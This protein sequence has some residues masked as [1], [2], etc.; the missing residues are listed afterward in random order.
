ML[1]TG[2]SLHGVIPTQKPL[3]WNYTFRYVMNRDRYEN[4]ETYNNED[5]M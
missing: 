3:D 2:V 4:V 1:P 5:F